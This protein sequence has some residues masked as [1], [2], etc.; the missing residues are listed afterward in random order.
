MTCGRRFMDTVGRR[1]AH[2]C[3]SSGNSPPVVAGLWSWISAESVDS[4]SAVGTA[5]DLSGNGRNWTQGTAG[6]KPSVAADARF[7]SRLAM[8]FDGTDDRLG[9]P[10][11]AALTSSTILVSIVVDADPPGAVAQSGLWTIGTS[12]LATHYPLTDSIIYDDCGT[13]ARKTVGNPTPPLTTARIYGVRNATN[14][15]TAY[16]DGS[17][18]FNTATSTPGFSATPLLGASVG[19]AQFLDGAI[20]D[21]IVYDRLLTTDE[22]A[23]VNAWLSAR[24]GK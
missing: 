24:A 13:N 20:R 16:I 10:T 4:T 12:G 11:M 8:V 21:F 23:M 22:F 1:R 5:Y 17:V 19:A 18:A 3:A 7:G 14:D 6:F 2:D 15:W 9:G